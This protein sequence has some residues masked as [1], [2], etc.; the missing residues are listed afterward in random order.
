MGK[1]TRAQR[2]GR[3]APTY[4]AKSWRREGEAK[5]P[6]AGIVQARIIDI[7]HDPGRSAPV[8]KVKYSGGG[9]GLL[10]VPEGMKV[11]DEI[12]LGTSVPISPG[13]VLPL[14]T[15][16]E[17]TRIYNIEARPGD[18]GRFTR[19]SGCYATLVAHDVGQAVV[20]LPSGEMKALDP[21][22]RAT[23]GAVAG[24]GRLEKPFVKAGKRYLAMLGRGKPY[25]HVRGVAMNVVDHPFGGGRGKHAGR[26]K[27]IRR[28]AP[29][30]QKVGLIAAKRVGER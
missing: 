6:P 22:C 23:V 4:R 1:Q 18:G 20:V 24:G 21:S 15:I 16:P 3:G 11:G 5:L 14:A 2:I 9:K 30:G 19:S 10:L 12:S 29:P 17:G 13:N 26:P 25:P 8:A 7:I 28:G 27:T